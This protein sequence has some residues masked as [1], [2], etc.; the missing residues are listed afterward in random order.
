MEQILINELI[1]YINK[2]GGEKI[3]SQLITETNEDDNPVLWTES[4]IDKAITFLHNI[5]ANFVKESA[6]EVII[7]L[8]VH[9]RL[10]EEDLHSC[11][12]ETEKLAANEEL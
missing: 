1:E 9:Y 7:S 4:E 2:S 8:Q 10:N 3:I 11:L 5:T 12:P 6:L